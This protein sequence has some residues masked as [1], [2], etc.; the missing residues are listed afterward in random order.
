MGLHPGPRWLP[1]STKTTSCTP[2]RLATLNLRR[3][4]TPAPLVLELIKTV[5]AVGPITVA[6]RLPAV[7][8]NTTYSQACNHEYFQLPPAR[9]GF[10][11]PN[12]PSQGVLHR[13]PALI[14]CPGIVC[15][16]T[17]VSILPAD[18]TTSSTAICSSALLCCQTAGRGSKRCL[19]PVQALRVIGQAFAS[20]P[21]MWALHFGQTTS[22]LIPP[23]A[24]LRGIWCCASA[25]W[26]NCHCAG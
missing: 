22:F 23:G 4:A 20:R 9:S 18:T 17:A 8:P 21:V 2:A 13:T 11:R 15:Q 5:L 19:L 16:H 7:S 1:D 6:H 24:A 25:S 14:G 10:S 3:K 12:L 26:P